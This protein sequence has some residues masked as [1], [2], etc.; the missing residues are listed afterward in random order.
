VTDRPPAPAPGDGQDDAHAEQVLSQALNL[1][2]GGGK[3]PAAPSA[4]GAG[5]S[6]R[7]LSTGQL[8]LLA[9]I[10]GLLVGIVA[11]FL[12]LML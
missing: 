6:T 8:I 7:R 5:R 9:A 12:S 2:A 1:M 11:G 10:I 4:A 3:S